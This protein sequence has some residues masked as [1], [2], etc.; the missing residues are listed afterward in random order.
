MYKQSMQLENAA[1]SDTFQ[2]EQNSSAN[3]M[4]ENY[5]TLEQEIPPTQGHVEIHEDNPTHAK[6]LKSNYWQVN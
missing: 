1:I 2:L 6:R 3:N 4:T 5:E